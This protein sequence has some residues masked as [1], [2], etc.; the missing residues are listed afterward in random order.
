MRDPQHI[1]VIGAGLIGTATAYEL[2]RRGF[3]VSVIDAA[4]GPGL[5]TSYANGGQISSCE[6]TPWAGPEVPGLILKWI[7]RPDGPFKLR[8][9]LDPVQ[10]RWLLQFLA[11]CRPGA[12]AERVPHNL[13][14]ALYSRGRMDALAQE[15]G[16]AGGQLA[17]DER[18]QGILRVYHQAHELEAAARDVEA[19]AA[20]G[21]RQDVL[22]AD[23][24]V[25]IEPALGL[26]KARG[27]LSGGIHSPD[28]RSGDAH[29]FVA[30]LE[31]AARALGARFRYGADVAGL[32]VEK[33]AVRGVRL[34][35]GED[36]DAEATVVA[37]GVGAAPLLRRIGV[38]IAVYPV[39]GYSLTLDANA[40]EGGPAPQ[41]S[42]TD[43]ERK[44]VVSRL[45]DRL[46]AAGTAEIAG[47]DLALDAARAEG[48]F[49]AL[50]S[51][52]PQTGAAGAPQ[53]WAGLRPMTP[54][55]SPL[56]GA[57]PGWRGLYV[58]T[59]HGTLGWTFAA[60]SGAALAAYLSGEDL[61]FDINDFAPDRL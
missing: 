49:A 51:L 35:D 27:G 55:G 29:L 58:N 44:I 2:A 13:K 30:C 60:G 22:D 32:I 5:G 45:G 47:Y 43:E 53:Y 4:D 16:A 28:D 14:L 18:R 7:G 19:F 39:K 38:R 48:V 50:Q 61:P 42:I 36:L 1:L 20:Q 17:F 9:K 26:L 41:V 52:L 21:V 6:V 59:G 40:L 10:W 37:N 25:A 34:A 3:G 24:C 15:I 23:G 8:P 56:I 54:D 31:D 57:V 11:R 12:R 33:G 46:R